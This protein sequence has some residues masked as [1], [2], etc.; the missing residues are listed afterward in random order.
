V[1]GANSG[2]GFPAARE[3][4]GCGAHVGLAVRDTVKGEKAAAR[5]SGPGSTSIAE[6][7][8]ADIDHVAGCANSMSDEWGTRTY[9]FP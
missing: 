1:T 9:R 5:L 4:V 7:E 3:L 2:I 6:L 8:L